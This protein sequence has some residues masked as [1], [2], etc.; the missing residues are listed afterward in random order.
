M[1]KNYFLNSEGNSYFKRNISTLTK[2]EYIT[3]GNDIIVNNIKN[4]LN[5]S[6]QFNI[7]EIGCSN[8]NRLKILNNMF[9]NNSYYGLDPSTD[10]IEYAKENY[11]NI[12][13]NVLTCDDMSL[14]EDKKFDIIMIPFVLMYID[15][16]LLLKSVAEI[17]RILSNNGILI[18]TDF[19]SNRQ[20]KNAYKHLE[21]TFIYKQNFFE[22]FLS[23]KNY[24][25]YKLEC[26]SHNT[27]N[28]NDNYDD[29]C[30]YVE[31][32]KDLLNLFN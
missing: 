7:L 26:F 20:R 11:E 14:F 4:I 29:T 28:N 21:N 10:A 16:E 5:S 15:R 13:F 31:L 17:D 1:N 3:G 22:I 18:I 23:S 12:N 6:E 9:P 25:L 27:S 19:Y 8:G 24:F 2:D 32:K 30:Y